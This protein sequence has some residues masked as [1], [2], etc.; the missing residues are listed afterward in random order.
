MKK[1]WSLASLVWMLEMKMDGN[2]IINPWLAALALP[3]LRLSTPSAEALE[4][5]C[6]YQLLFQLGNW[7]PESFH[8]LPKDTQL[9]RSHKAETWG[10]LALPAM[11]VVPAD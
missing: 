3:A 5:E 7:G 1:S 10:S 11:L 6:P 2:V 9:M 8:V 4:C